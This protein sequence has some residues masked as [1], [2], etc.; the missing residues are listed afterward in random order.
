MPQ[1]RART[2]LASAVFAA[3]SL[4]VATPGDATE[5]SE[6]PPL[7]AR[8]CF[9]ATKAAERLSG[10]PEDLLHAIALTETGVYRAA[11]GARVAWPWTIN[12]EGEG[13][14]FP[15]KQAAVEGV[16]ALIRS[17]V[18][19]IDVGCMQVNLKHHPT[20]FRSLEEAFDPVINVAYAT[21]FLLDLKARHK[22]WGAA[23]RRYH[24]ALASRNTHYRSKVHAEW[25][26]LRRHDGAE[27]HASIL[28]APDKS[29]GASAGQSPPTRRTVS[30]TP[31][32]YKAQRLA[33]QRARAL[34]FAPA[35]P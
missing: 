16:R 11:A 9:E 14:Y 4:T 13:R 35:T 21:S 18:Y 20:A 7:D 1:L 19:S 30:T 2:L 3:L 27:R 23:V 12:A 22:S 34:A 17:G 29:A 26:A 5:R 33:E 32:G 8:L 24:S 25:R 28:S 10:A 31:R 15:T 6:P